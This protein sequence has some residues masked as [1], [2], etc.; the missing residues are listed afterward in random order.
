MCGVS[1]EDGIVDDHAV[2]LVVLVGFHDLLL[3]FLLVDLAKLKVEAAEEIVLA[4]LLLQLLSWRPGYEGP[5]SQVN[6]LIYSLVLTCLLRPLGVFDSSRVVVSQ[7]GSEGGLAIGAALDLLE[8]ILDLG[9][10]ALGNGIGHDDLTGLGDVRSGSHC[11]L[12]ESIS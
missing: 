1:G 6:S 12:F 3:K 5:P 2:H 4:Q 11:W 10:Q 8:S 7:E 9:Q